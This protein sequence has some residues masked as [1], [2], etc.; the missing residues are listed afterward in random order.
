MK[1]CFF[2]IVIYKIKEVKGNTIHIFKMNNFNALTRL[3]KKKK[4]QK[5]FNSNVKF[6]VISRILG[7]TTSLPHVF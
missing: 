3:E 2:V 1:P 7:I 4:E 5:E 6:V